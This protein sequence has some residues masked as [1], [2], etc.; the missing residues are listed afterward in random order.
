MPYNCFVIH[1]SA[2]LTDRSALD[3]VNSFGHTG[4]LAGSGVLLEDTLGCRTAHLSLK[5]GEHRRSLSLVAG[6]DC[7]INLLHCSLDARLSRFVAGCL[8]CIYQNS[9]LRRFDVSQISLPP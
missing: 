6:L 5:G 1:Y 9:F 2:V 7:R 4:D 8:L 3:L